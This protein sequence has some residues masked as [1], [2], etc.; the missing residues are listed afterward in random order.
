MGLKNLTDN[1]NRSFETKSDNF[2]MDVG[3]HTSTHKVRSM[4][5]ILNYVP[6]GPNRVRADRRNVCVKTGPNFNNNEQSL[7]SLLIIISKFIIIYS[8]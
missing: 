8:C 4:L 6:I 2:E 5:N 3:K 1:H 7:V